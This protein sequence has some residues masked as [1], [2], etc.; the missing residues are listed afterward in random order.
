MRRALVL[1][2]GIAACTDAKTV[3]DKNVTAIEVAT[4]I[5]APS[6]LTQLRISG[7]ANGTDAFAPGSVPETPRP[8]A[9][10]QTA[11]VLLP[12]SLDGT[13][14]DVRVDGMAG[15]AVAASGV[16]MVTVRAHA[17]TR[18]DVALGAPAICGDGMVV[19]PI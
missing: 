10:E 17:V 16:A 11:V 3:V 5:D 9:G 4:Q 19:S 8:L 6:A 7:R 1:A 15:G 18:V 14:I 13:S 12:D 2:I